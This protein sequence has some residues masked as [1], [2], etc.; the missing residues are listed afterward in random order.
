MYITNTSESSID[1]STKKHHFYIKATDGGLASMDKTRLDFIQAISRHD[2]EYLC[3]KE[4]ID[5]NKQRL[6]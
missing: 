3:Y 2:C 1:Y 4:I 6:K 5:L